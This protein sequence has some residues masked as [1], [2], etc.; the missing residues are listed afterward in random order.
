MSLKKFDAAWE[1]T[2]AAIKIDPKFAAAHYYLG[3][4]Y[5]L[6]KKRLYATLA[7][8]K[9]QNDLARQKKL[10]G[11]GFLSPSAL[12]QAEMAV[13]VQTKSLEAGRFAY[14]GAE[15]DLGRAP[16]ALEQR[17]DLVGRA[18]ARRLGHARE[19]RHRQP[20][21][22]RRRVGGR[23]PRRP[24]APARPAH[25]PGGRPRPRSKTG[26]QTPEGPDRNGLLNRLLPANCGHNP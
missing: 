15:P 23:R 11:E 21:P 13:R 20:G 3:L 24:L 4:S 2:E 18:E 26:P 6:Q 19:V 1:D 22:Q 9:A 14:E 25:P 10:Q 16:A 17:D 5:L 12:D 8:E 7:L